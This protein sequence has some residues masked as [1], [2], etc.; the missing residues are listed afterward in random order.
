MDVAVLHLGANSFQLLHA[1]VTSQWRVRR[2]S[3]AREIVRFGGRNT[4]TGVID[5]ASWS[6][7]LDAVRRLRDS[8]LHLGANRLVA[9]ATGAIR[10]A[11]NGAVFCAAVRR[12]HSVDVEVLSSTQQTALAYRGA[13]SDVTCADDEPVAVLDV[14][15]GYIYA[16]VGTGREVLFSTSLPL[17]VERLHNAFAVGRL[18]EDGA[19]A[20][21]SVVRMSAQPLVAAVRK[22][23]PTRMLFASGTAR[24]VHRLAGEEPDSPL[25]RELC[26]HD[27]VSAATWAREASD[28][29]LLER[30]VQPSRL[31]TA[32]IAVG[33]M[34]TLL[35]ALGHDTIT[36]VKSGMREG[37]ALR[38]ARTA[39]ALG[40]SDSGVGQ[41]EPYAA[42]GLD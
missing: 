24:A 40:D 8:A 29:D 26:R 27:L 21:A 22:L 36:V 32:P 15:A 13:R 12:L 35:D 37:V 1:R 19:E 10:D 42:N 17:G 11:V 34:E 28:R 18:D 23:R 41:P 6:N 4:A 3:S 16:A 14:G 30:G 7:G 5:D 25:P 9:V 2:L 39:A 38:E 33:I 31:S 20:M